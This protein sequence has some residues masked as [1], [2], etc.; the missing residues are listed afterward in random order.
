MQVD[1]YRCPKCNTF[2]LASEVDETAWV[3]PPSVEPNSAGHG[4]VEVS[5]RPGPLICNS[6]T[7]PHPVGMKR[8]TVDLAGVP[9]HGRFGQLGKIVRREGGARDD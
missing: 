3:W 1:R 7:H 6:D 5:V 4:M 2:V 9:H 8:E